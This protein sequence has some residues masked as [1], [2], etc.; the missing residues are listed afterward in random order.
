MSK[1][2]EFTLKLLGSVILVIIR[3]SYLSLGNLREYNLKC[4]IRLHV[5]FERFSFE[6]QHL[7]M[8]D[9]WFVSESFAILAKNDIRCSL[10]EALNKINL[11][12]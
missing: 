9:A 10:G 2:I 12:F 5:E 11:I 1:D 7:I 3:R 8:T 6:M 4:Q